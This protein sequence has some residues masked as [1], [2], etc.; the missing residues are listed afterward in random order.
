MMKP[1]ARSLVFPVALAVVIAAVAIY[2]KLPEFAAATVEPSHN[3]QWSLSRTA[4]ENGV[5]LKSLQHELSHLY[6]AAYDFPTKGVAVSDLP[7]SEADVRVAVAEARKE[8]N[9]A[10]DVLKFGLWG[11]LL[12]GVLVL[13]RTTKKIRRVRVYAMIGAAVI[14]GVLLGGSPGPMEGFVKFVKW[15]KGLEGNLTIR[16]GV[17]GLF[18]AM[19]VAGN[20]LICGWGC[21]L[22][23]LQEGLYNV[24]DLRRGSKR[25]KRVKPHFRFTNGIRTLLLAVA[26]CLLFGWVFGVERFVLYHNVNF[27]KLFD[28]NLAT[29]AL[30]SLPVFAVASLFV[31][32]PFCAFVCPFGWYSWLLELVSIR[33]VRIKTEACIHCDACVRA[34]PTHAMQQRIHTRRR[35]LLAECWACGECIESCPTD[36]VAFIGPTEGHVSTLP[37]VS[38]EEVNRKREKYRDARRQA[39]AKS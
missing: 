27:F 23:A 8:V 2:L 28:W 19:V 26:L 15:M 39:A 24:L 38:D 31:F 29:V 5:E 7:I 3:P 37:E 35:V 33:R 32:R 34:C 30:Y 6:P 16:L 4:N 25:I 22:G 13:F 1:S 17:L 11:V 10:K 21:Q 36:A 9:P 14:F 18:T 12:A 20:K